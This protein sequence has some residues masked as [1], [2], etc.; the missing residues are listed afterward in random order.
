MESMLIGARHDCV[1]GVADVESAMQALA[2]LGYDFAELVLS[3]EEIAGLEPGAAALY[4]EKAAQVNL[5]ILS[6][7]MGHF[8]NFAAAAPEQRA[9]IVRHISALIGFTRDVGGDLI[10]LATTEAS[11]K[12]RDYAGV[13]RSELRDVA[14]EAAAAG[15]TLALE[16]VGWFKPFRLAELVKRIDHPAIRVYF[17][18]GNCLYVGESPLAQARICAPHTAQIHIKGGPAAPLAAMPLRELRGVFEAAG[19]QGRGCLEI[20]GGR[21]HRGLAEAKGL[22]KMAGYW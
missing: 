17:D 18:M 6:T 1:S 11:D 8:G 16:H 13:Y 10:L 2:E 7:S 14:E 9:E 15:V 20:A 22:L 21:G 12:V 19:F 4:K 5:P 3:R